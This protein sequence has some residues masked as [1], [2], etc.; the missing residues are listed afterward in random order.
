MSEIRDGPHLSSVIILVVCELDLLEAD[1]LFPELF[2]GEGGVWMTVESVRWG[3]IRLTGH[4]PGGTVVGVTVALV[5]A[6]DD[7]QQD[8]IAGFAINTDKTAS[9]S[10]KHS[11]GQH[12]G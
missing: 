11:P 6:R 5:V 8:L 9:Q 1:D 10:W 7:V 2:P 4:Q 3:R 12:N